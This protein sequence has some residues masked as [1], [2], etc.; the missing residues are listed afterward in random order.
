MA[1]GWVHAGSA[2]EARL[3]ELSD[4]LLAAASAG[5]MQFASDEPERHLPDWD[6]RALLRE[7]VLKEMSR[8]RPTQPL[9]MEYKD[10]LDTP[11]GGVTQ[12]RKMA[13]HALH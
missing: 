5:T 10:R 3:R 1:F 8:C 2:D 13:T 4:E 7:T 6:R 12:P 9:A 11:T